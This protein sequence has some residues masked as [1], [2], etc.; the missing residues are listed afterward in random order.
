VLFN[1]FLEKVKSYLDEEII[2]GI[3]LAFN[4]KYTYKGSNLMKSKNKLFE[5][6]DNY[7]VYCDLL[8]SNISFSTNNFI[9]NFINFNGQIQSFKECFVEF[10]D[11][12]DFFIKFVEFVKNKEENILLNSSSTKILLVNTLSVKIFLELGRSLEENV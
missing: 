1:L 4:H 5:V 3:I 6:I 12:L 7:E 9:D 2:N 8:I 10:I 11:K